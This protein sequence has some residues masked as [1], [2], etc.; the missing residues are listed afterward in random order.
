MLRGDKRKPVPLVQYSGGVAKILFRELPDELRSKYGFDPQ[1]EKAYLEASEAQRAK[2]AFAAA[3]NAASRVY[4]GTIHQVLPD[5]ALFFY[6]ETRE[7]VE[8][9]FSGYVDGERWSGR[10]IPAG[11]YSCESVGAGIKTFTK[12]L[13]VSQ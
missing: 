4:Y 10:V 7:F 9:D 6:G 8:D 12:Y 2:A 5:G 13:K 11:S 3:L 1:K